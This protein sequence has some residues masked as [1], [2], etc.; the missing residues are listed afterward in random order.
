MPRPHTI[1]KCAAINLGSIKFFSF[2]TDFIEPIAFRGWAVQ[3]WSVLAADFENHYSSESSQYINFFLLFSIFFAISCKNGGLQKYWRNLL[4]IHIIKDYM[5][6]PI[7]IGA[8]YKSCELSNWLNCPPFK[9][10]S[11]IHGLCVWMI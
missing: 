11:N 4:L 7:K 5:H 9:L 2:K 8:S 3:K 1:W 6:R 10:N